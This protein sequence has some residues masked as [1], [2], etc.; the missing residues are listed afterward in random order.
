M[1]DAVAPPRP[2]PLDCWGGPATC[3]DTWVPHGV[4]FWDAL[5][6]YFLPIAF[7]GAVLLLTA[8]RMSHAATAHAA[9]RL[10]GSSGGTAAAVAAARKPS[11]FLPINAWVAALWAAN[12]LVWAGAAPWT[13]DWRRGA[14][15]VDGPVVSVTQVQ[16]ILYAAACI[17]ELAAKADGFTWLSYAH[18]FLAVVDVSYIL[19]LVRN[20]YQIF[21]GWLYLGNTYLEAA[22]YGSLC[23]HHAAAL[24]DPTTRRGQQLRTLSVAAN[25]AQLYFTACHNVAFQFTANAYVARHWGHL[26]P[27][28]AYSFLAFNVVFL[29]ENVYCVHASAGTLVRKGAATQTERAI[30]RA[31]AFVRGIATCSCGA[32]GG[33]GKPVEAARALG[34]A[35]TKCIAAAPDGGP[36]RAPVPPAIM[37]V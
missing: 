11:P 29:L 34:F 32:A 23:L 20:P 6:P 27:L 18:H 3:K 31:T 36:C 1:A 12:L 14:L 25:R 2:P 9:H 26:S 7:Y 28:F 33:G 35:D 15:R 30:Y 16:G 5:F 8:L 19:C 17:I 24:T 4:T 21:V 37:A 22:L 10:S 13:I